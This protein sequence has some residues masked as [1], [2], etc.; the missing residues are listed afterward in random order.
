MSKNKIVIY[1][2]SFAIIWALRVFGLGIF[3]LK[4][5]I[6]VFFL[7]I[8]ILII[9]LFAEYL[10][11]EKVK[12]AELKAETE[13]D[14]QTRMQNLPSQLIFKDSKKSF[15]FVV[16]FSFIL[17]QILNISNWIIV[18]AAGYNPTGFL[19]G[20]S[21]GAILFVIWVAVFCLNNSTISLDKN[22]LKL[23]EFTFWCQ[24]KNREIGVLEIQKLAKFAVRQ[25]GSAVTKSTYKIGFWTK[26][27]EFVPFPKNIVESELKAEKI[28]SNL[29][30]FKIRENLDFEI[31]NEKYQTQMP[32]YFLGGMSN[33]AQI[34]ILIIVYFML[35]ILGTLLFSFF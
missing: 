27:E 28:M 20:W 22:Q 12:I 30:L 5:L 10:E 19:V 34:A 11:Q 14:A 23:S 31:Q 33:F 29:A 17:F 18:M 16:I 2:A 1:L 24:R 3:S 4:D 15:L 6:A 35:P 8:P 9:L 21:F 32:N 25:R 7:S 13:T 26:S